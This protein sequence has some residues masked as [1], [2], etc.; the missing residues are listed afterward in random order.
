[1]E[2]KKILIEN[3]ETGIFEEKPES[4]S[5]FI[6][7]SLTKIGRPKEYLQKVYKLERFFKL[8]KPKSFPKHVKLMKEKNEKFRKKFFKS[9]TKFCNN[10]NNNQK[11]FANNILKPNLNLIKEVNI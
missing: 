10:H 11:N 2:D 9:R 7:D 4:V 8:K 3:E 6:K 5:H 1:L